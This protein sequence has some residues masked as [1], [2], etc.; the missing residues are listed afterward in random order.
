MKR[1][2]ILFAI[3]L[4]LVACG[5]DNSQISV[6]NNSQPSYLPAI[7]TQELPQGDICAD[8]GLEV[9]AG[10]DLNDDKVIDASEVTHTKILCRGA[11]GI[12]SLVK[13]FDEP[14]GERCLAGGKKITTGLDMDGDKNLSAEEV[15]DTQYWCGA[16]LAASLAAAQSTLVRVYDEPVGEICANGGKKIATGNDLNGNKLLDIDEVADVQY[17]C[18]GIDGVNG[19]DGSA[20]RISETIACSGPLQDWPDY[21]WRYKRHRYDNGDVF[22]SA[23]VMNTATTID[24]NEF[25][26]AQ[27]LTTRPPSVQFVYDVKGM[28]NWG[29]WTIY[30]D[31][32]Q[33]KTF[34]LY[35]DQD[36]LGTLP[37]AAATTAIW[38]MPLDKCKK[39]IF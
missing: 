25:Y 20:N 35:N 37:D 3:I 23:A 4:L 32:S 27:E 26:A 15:T 1:F 34:V 29:N 12:N 31:E 30:L 36:L 39:T 28:A 33:A 19:I 17:V 13:I 5:K 10:I 22:V 21:V 7:A 18:N 24:A 2:S 6:E 38:S 16:D 9:T 11:A 14:V 8:G